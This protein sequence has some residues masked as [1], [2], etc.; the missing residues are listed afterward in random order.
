GHSNETA[1]VLI[2]THKTTRDALDHAMA[3]FAATG[4]VEGEPVAIR[5]EEV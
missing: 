2:V 5:I 1:P 4:V 3:G